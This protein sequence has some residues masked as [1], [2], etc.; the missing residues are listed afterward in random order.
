MTCSVGRFSLRSAASFLLPDR[1]MASS[2]SLTRY[3]MIVDFRVERS[4][5][6]LV[7][8]VSMTDSLW[9]SDETI[10]WPC[11]DASYGQGGCRAPITF[12]VPA[13]KAPKRPLAAGCYRS[14]QLRWIEVIF[15]PLQVDEV[16]DE[17]QTEPQRALI[18]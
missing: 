8:F 14:G 15:T 16:F 18:G 12:L 13:V 7:A 10:G 6:D 3:N 4:A 17:P 1:S 11:D 9:I 5:H 2:V